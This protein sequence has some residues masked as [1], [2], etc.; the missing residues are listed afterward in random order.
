MEK[1]WGGRSGRNGDPC[2]PQAGPRPS[3]SGRLGLSREVVAFVLTASE[4]HG[5]RSQ[6]GSVASEP[7]DT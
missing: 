4:P 5:P 7:V 3:S 1:T 2:L 6:S